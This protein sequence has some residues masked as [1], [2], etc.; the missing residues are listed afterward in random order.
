MGGLERSQKLKSNGNRCKKVRRLIARAELANWLLYALRL[1]CE[2]RTYQ[3][4]KAMKLEKRN[5]WYWGETPKGETYMKYGDSA[6][7]IEI[8]AVA[9]RGTFFRIPYGDIPDGE[10]LIEG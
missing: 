3:G 8:A 2:V 4:W 6:R 1:R 5:A 9:N 10:S 7:G